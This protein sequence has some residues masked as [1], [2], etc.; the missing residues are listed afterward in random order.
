MLAL[1]G[2]EVTLYYYL[3]YLFF[4]KINGLV[5]IFKIIIC[6]AEEKYLNCILYIN[7]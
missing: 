4:Y 2:F 7:N 5:I 1:I 6:H 3:L